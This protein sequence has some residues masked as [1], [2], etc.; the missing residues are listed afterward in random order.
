MSSLEQIPVS[1]VPAGDGLSGNADAL[2]AEIATLLARWLDEGVP[3]SIDLRGLPLSPADLDYLRERLG[4]GEVHAEVEALGTSAI[5]ETAFAG[6]WWITHRN[7]EQE[8][9]AELIEINTV[10]DILKSPQE[11]MRDGLMRLRRQ[12]A[13]PDSVPD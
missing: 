3:G 7:I 10:P 11:D 5:R 12:I 4:T 9:M 6:V 2:L 13:A 1:I 8:V